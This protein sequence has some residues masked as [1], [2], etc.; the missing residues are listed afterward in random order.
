MNTC[1]NACS[2]EQPHKSINMHN[3]TKPTFTERHTRTRTQTGPV[4]LAGRCSHH[5]G[6]S[7]GTMAGGQNCLWFFTHVTDWAD[8][9]LNLP[10][11]NLT[12]L[13]TYPLS[14]TGHLCPSL[15]DTQTPLLMYEDFCRN[16]T[17][18][19][20][21][22]TYRNP[23]PHIPTAHTGAPQPHTRTH[24]HPATAYTNFT[25]TANIMYTMAALANTQQTYSYTNCP[26]MAIPQYADHVCRE[27]KEGNLVE[28]CV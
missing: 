13:H 21:H 26:S 27:G 11:C 7:M 5:I 4:L 28:A 24:V 19:H 10:P 2:W 3:E 9:N 1:G 14:S 20:T 6:M 16:C 15:C 12:G 23:E 18:M 25:C 8:P 17:H 22:Y